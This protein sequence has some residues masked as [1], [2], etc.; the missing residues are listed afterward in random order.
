MAGGALRMLYDA[1]GGVLY[2]LYGFKCVFV[3]AVWSWGGC[4][5]AI[6]GLGGS[7]STCMT[8]GVLLHVLCGSGGL[9]I[10]DRG[11][12]G[13][14]ISV[15]WSWGAL[16]VFWVSLCGA[17]CLGGGSMW[18]VLGALKWGSLCTL[19]GPWGSLNMPYGPKGEV[20]LPV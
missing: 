17:W 8:V 18:V 10:C 3:H 19:Y 4:L 9:H 2:M 16:Y 12:L 20:L 13:S 1:L 7:T 6:C 14:S 15:L 11:Y 5:Q